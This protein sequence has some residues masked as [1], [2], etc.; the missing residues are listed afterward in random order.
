VTTPKIHGP[1]AVYARRVSPEND[2]VFAPGWAAIDAALQSLYGEQTP[3][4][5]GYIPPM[6]FSHNLQGCSA[7]DA[8]DHWHYVTYGLSDLY[9]KDPADDPEFSKWGLEST[10]RIAKA[11]ADGG[12][13]PGWPFDLLNRIANWVNRDAVLI[14]PGMRVDFGQPI[15]GHPTV[16][17]AP[18]TALTILAVT[19]D[20]QLPEINTPNGR[21]WFLQLVGVT[22]TEKAEMVASSTADVLAGLAVGNPLLVTDVTRG[23]SA[24]TV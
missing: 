24:P 2:T 11:R 4:H 19:P 6:A 22:P 13:A 14:E 7:Y 9:E 10:I 16:A 20:P 15:T 1:I 3:R 18:P 17:D 21:V 8:G 5:V 12:Q 23:V